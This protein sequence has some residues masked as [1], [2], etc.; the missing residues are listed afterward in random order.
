MKLEVLTLDQCQMVRE[1]RNERLETLRTSYRITE[2]MQ[3]EFYDKIS[4]RDSP[5]RYYAI[6]DGGLFLG[7]GGLTNIQWEN[8]TAEISLILK[9][10][11]EHDRRRVYEL[12]FD[13]GFANMGLLTTTG[14]VYQCNDLEPMI[15]KIIEGFGGY[16]TEMIGRKF[17]DGKLY[18]A[19][20]FG[21]ISDVYKQ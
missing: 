13:E 17:W 11:N 20:W 16:T 19:T 8:R 1:W 7:M 6:M 9:N 12:L 21:V 15:K 2:Q 14:E 5:H 10:E 18:N 4:R 3:E